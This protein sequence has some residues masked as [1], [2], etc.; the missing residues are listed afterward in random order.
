MR[1]RQW[2][3]LG[4]H[5]KSQS[6]KLINLLKQF[7]YILK[8]NFRGKCLWSMKLYILSLLQIRCFKMAVKDVV[9]LRPGCAWTFPELFVTCYKLGNYAF[10]KYF[11][12]FKLFSYEM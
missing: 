12:K 3:Y 10:V 7:K 6:V 2:I 5:N 8:I 11:V 9:T 1:Y 4:I